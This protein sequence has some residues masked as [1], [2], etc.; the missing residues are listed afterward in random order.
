MLLVKIWKY[1]LSI[2]LILTLVSFISLTS[3]FVSIRL[4]IARLIFNIFLTFSIFLERI[5][6]NVNVA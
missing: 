1:D 5:L 2:Q 6:I 3:K 4:I